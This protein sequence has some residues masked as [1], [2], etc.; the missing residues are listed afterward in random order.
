MLVLTRKVGQKL[1]IGDNITIVVNR[2]S[3]NRVSLGIEAPSEV[4]I[5]RGEL[6]QVR[7]EFQERTG[8]DTE[9]GVMAPDLATPFEVSDTFS[10]HLP[11]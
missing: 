2:I 6:Q 3:G 4:A 11:R 10:A 5:V 9:S 1:V 7:D 8:I